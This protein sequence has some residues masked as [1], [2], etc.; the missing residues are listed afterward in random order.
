MRASPWAVGCLLIGASV[1]LLGSPVAQA[2]N[3]S[4]VREAEALGFA[5]GP[6]NLISTAQSACYFLGRNRHS[7]EVERR[8]VRYLRVEP[9]QGHQFLTLAVAQYCPQYAGV[10]G[11]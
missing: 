1:A 3:G 10:V 7:V 2:D 5:H 8:I 11:V 9:T 6:E 4:F